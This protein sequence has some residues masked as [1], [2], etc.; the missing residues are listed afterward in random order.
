MAAGPQLRAYGANLTQTGRNVHEVRAVVQS[1]RQ[2]IDHIEMII[3]AIDVIEQRADEFGDTVAKLKLALKLMDKTGPLKLVAKAGMAVLDG[4]Q[5]VAQAIEDKADQLA[6]KI[7]DSRLEQKLAHAGERLD[8]TDVALAT[9]ENALLF[10]AAVIGGL[11]RTLD[12]IDALDPTGDPGRQVADAADALVMP[13]NAALAA[14]N[15]GFADVRSLVLSLQA[16]VPDARFLPALGVRVAFDKIDASLDFLRGPLDVVARVL[17]PVEGI[18]DAVGFIFN[19]VVGPVIDFVMNTLG[20]D[21]LMASVSA[22]INGLLPDAGVLDPLLAD[23]DTAFEKL[24]PLGSLDDY[25]GVTAWL[26][27]IVEDMLDPV[28]SL[29]SGPIGIGTAQSDRLQ[30]TSAAEVLDAGAGDDALSGGAGDDLLMA[31]PGN[32]L[33]DGETGHDTAVFRGSFFE[34]SYSQAV[35]GDSITFQ[36]LRPTLPGARDGIDET[37]NIETFTFA[38]LSLTRQQLLESVIVAGAG[39]TRLE[40]S[41]QTDLLLA[42]SSAIT[43]D[44]RGGNDVLVGSPANDTLLGGGGDDTVLRSGGNDTIDGGA[45]SDTWRFALDHSSGNP[46]IDVDLA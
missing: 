23:I 9:V 14:L 44:A 40:G 29:Q 21:R 26:D 35:Q 39:Q 31:G 20:I 11:V 27:D 36:H 28:G 2:Q 46:P 7:D 15:D 43:I 5:R 38:D 12:T 10:D 25:L 32:D 1:V 19:L 16:A 45:G 22:R 37:R 34:Y 6:R 18:L 13:P 17:K 33:L 41:E 4:V 24:D 3:D 8:T 42:G 30:G